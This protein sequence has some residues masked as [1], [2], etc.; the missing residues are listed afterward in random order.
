MQG[1][2]FRHESESASR[3]TATENGQRTDANEDLMLA[4]LG[5]EVG[6]VVVVVNHSH[7][8]S[9]PSLGSISSSCKAR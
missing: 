5:V 7:Y 2:P 1:S 6:R 4:V 3:E 8:P 9:Y